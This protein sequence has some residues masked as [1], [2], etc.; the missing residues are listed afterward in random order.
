MVNS[1]RPSSNTLS[2]LERIET[3]DSELDRLGLI[4]AENGEVRDV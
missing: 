3:M 4:V 2:L 1:M